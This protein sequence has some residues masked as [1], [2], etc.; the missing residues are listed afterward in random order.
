ML[1]EFLKFSCCW[2]TQMST[3]ALYYLPSGGGCVIIPPHSI[4]F[5]AHW[6]SVDIISCSLDNS[7]PPNANRFFEENPYVRSV[8]STKAAHVESF[9]RDPSKSRSKKQYWQKLSNSD[10]CLLNVKMYLLYSLF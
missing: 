7:D 1:L 10:D 5:D 2:K 4:S 3:A 9:F 8:L 6:W